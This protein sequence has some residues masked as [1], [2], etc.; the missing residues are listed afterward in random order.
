MRAEQHGLGIENARFETDDTCLG[1]NVFCFNAFCCSYRRVI[2]PLTYVGTNGND[3]FNTSTTNASQYNVF[4]ALDGDDSIT[5]NFGGAVTID[6]GEG[7][8]RIVLGSFVNK[9]VITSGTGNDYIDGRNQASGSQYINS[10]AGNDWIQGGG[11]SAV[12][13]VSGSDEVFGSGAVQ[14]SNSYYLNAGSSNVYGNGAANYFYANS[15]GNHLNG[16]YANMSNNYLGSINYYYLAGP[17]GKRG[18]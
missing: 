17:G 4:Y 8:N 6:G 18:Q 12:Y 3:T 1:R 13:V 9:A 16:G 10:G 5:T 2:M 15:T 7:S 14:A 11:S